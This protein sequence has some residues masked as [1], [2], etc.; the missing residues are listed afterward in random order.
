MSTWFQLFLK[1]EKRSFASTLRAAT[2]RSSWCW[3]TSTTCSRCRRAS[4]PRR[5]RREFLCQ[6]RAASTSIRAGAP[7]ICRSEQHTRLILLKQALLTSV[8]DLKVISETRFEHSS[9]STAGDGERNGDAG[10]AFEYGGHHRQRRGRQRQ[11]SRLQPQ[12]LQ[13]QGARDSP[14]GNSGHNCHGVCFISSQLMRSTFWL[15]N[16]GSCLAG[17]IERALQ[18]ILLCTS[19]ATDVDTGQ[20][21]NVCYKIEAG[22]GSEL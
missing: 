7:T 1:T 4:A 14:E 11:R 20:N 5:C 12:N 15:K 3:T 2:R 10:S 19:Q 8:D 17:Q 16:P 18:V 6:T 21:G 22:P 9:P 13:R